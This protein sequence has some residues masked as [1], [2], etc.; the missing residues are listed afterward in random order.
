MSNAETSKLGMDKLWK[1]MAM[2]SLPEIEAARKTAAHDP[3][4]LEQV[5]RV[6]CLLCLPIVF[7]AGKNRERVTEQQRLVT[8]SAQQNQLSAAQRKASCARCPTTYF[9]TIAAPSASKKYASLRKMRLEW[10]RQPLSTRRPHLAGHLYGHRLA[11]DGA[12]AAPGPA[13][14]PGDKGPTGAFRPNQRATFVGGSFY[15]AEADGDPERVPIGC[16]STTRGA[17]DRSTP[18]PSSASTARVARVGP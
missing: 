13:G 16:A 14:W 4:K 2:S 9:S 12:D 17:T 5:V 15:A 3:H 18:C 1:D 10:T 11:A 7:D 6:L 8:L